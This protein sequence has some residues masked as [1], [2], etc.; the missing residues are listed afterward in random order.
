[1]VAVL[2]SA[3]YESWLTGSLNPYTVIL[4]IILTLISEP[5]LADERDPLQNDGPA[6]PSEEHTAQAL[7]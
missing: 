7:V 2:F 4:V 5:E 3:L 6:N 1:M